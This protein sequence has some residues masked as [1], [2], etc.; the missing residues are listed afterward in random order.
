MIKL[1]VIKHINFNLSF[2]NKKLINKIF[3]FLCLFFIS[4]F[5]IKPVFADNESVY[6]SFFNSSFDN[7]SYV[8][9][10]LV[11]INPCVN[12]SCNDG[13]HCVSGDCLLNLSY[14]NV[15]SHVVYDLSYENWTGVIV[16]LYDDFS[17][18]NIGY[19]VFFDSRA[20]YFNDVQDSVLSVLSNN[21]FFLKYKFSAINGFAGYVS[22]SGLNLLLNDSRVEYVFND[23]IGSA[24]LEES[25]PLIDADDV[26]DVT[27]NNLNVSGLYQSVCVIDS[28]V[29]ASHP[30][31]EGKVLREICFC[32][33]DNKIDEYGC[34]PDGSFYDVDNAMDDNGHGTHVAGIIAANGSLK[35]VA[36]GSNIVAVK[37]LNST[38]FFWDSDLVSAIDWCVSNKDT[39]NISVISMSLGSINDLFTSS[40]DSE[41]IN[42]RD[43]I[44]EAV[45][46]GIFV[47][48]A[49]GNNGNYSY[50]ASPAC[51]SN[52]TAVGATYDEESSGAY[53]STADCTDY[54][55]FSD[56]LC[57][58]GNR[59]SILDVFAPGSLI[60]STNMSFGGYVEKRGTSA[61]APHVAGVAAL[62]R[63]AN[64]SLLPGEIRDV[65]VRTGVKVF[66]PNSSLYFSR[67]DAYRSVMASVHD[68]FVSDSDVFNST[69]NHSVF[70][71][72]VFNDKDEDVSNIFWG[73]DFGEGNST[74]SNSI[75]LGAYEDLWVFVEYEYGS[76]GN[77]TVNA[78]SNSSAEIGNAQAI[79]FESIMP[80]YDNLKL[81]NFTIMNST[82]L[83]RIFGFWIENNGSNDLVDVNWQLRNNTSAVITSNNFNLNINES[84]LVGIQYEYPESGTHTMTAITDYDDNI[85]EFNETDNSITITD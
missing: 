83:S 51:I 81:Y 68:V 9:E 47:D 80:S 32:D 72:H 67:V 36:Y 76:R 28:G 34:C 16:R 4:L 66:D 48:A 77:F 10:T 20:D 85:Y 29:N 33:D 50:I 7:L 3:I 26:W 82:G 42:Y 41:Y 37:V 15:D 19:M 35:G 30:D 44:N 57:C 54:N 79:S 21:D 25:V 55:I 53:W 17:F 63:Q 43:E 6:D 64:N 58:G 60:N 65:M 1:Y 22:L 24:F 59:G 78:S 69:G 8:N 18:D 11:N 70:S 61:S 27:I 73:L 46:A 40:C 39:Y 38:N 84:I 45:S 2:L 14:T 75:D 12:I 62:M 56:M 5:F 31:L 74:H 71:F 23:D 49:S 52:V 13:F